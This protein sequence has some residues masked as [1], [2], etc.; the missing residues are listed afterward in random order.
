MT[1]RRV[2]REPRLAYV[3]VGAS[4][5]AIPASAA[6]LMTG[7]SGAAT[8]PQ[9]T[10]SA[11][12]SGG[13]APRARVAR[14]HVRPRTMNALSGQR[15]TIRGRLAPGLP[16][17]RVRL[18]AG[19]GR[20]WNTIASSQTGNRGGF[21]VRYTAGDLGSQRLRVVYGSFDSAREAE[22]AE[23]RLPPKYQQA[24]RTAPRSFSELRKQM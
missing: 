19:R 9:T 10:S 1:R 15:I 21:R 23:R 13:T 6:A 3:A 4:M 7:S 14:V 22:D 17:R 18:E 11:R 5:L 2:L 8:Q 24:F 16:W 20:G 12:A